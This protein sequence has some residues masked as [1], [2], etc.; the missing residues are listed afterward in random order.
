MT[1]GGWLSLIVE[2][3]GIAALFGACGWLGKTGA[4]KVVAWQIRRE[5]KRIAAAQRESERARM[6]R[7]GLY[8]LVSAEGRGV[9]T[10][11][12]K[13]RLVEPVDADALADLLLMDTNEQVH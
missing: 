12:E 7:L 6:D 10:F 3:L 2:V 5:V 8:V 13:P 9:V 4:D 11:T 1:V